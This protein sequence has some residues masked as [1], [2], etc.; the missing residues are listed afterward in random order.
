MRNSLAKFYDGVIFSKIFPT[1]LL[2]WI[3]LRLYLSIF[4]AVF[5]KIYPFT[6]MEKEISTWP[7]IVDVVIWFQRVFFAPWLRWDAVWYLELLTKGYSANNGSTSFHPL[8]ALLSKPL[9]WLGVEPLFSL[10]IT[11][12]LFCLLFFL[13]FYKFSRLDLS[14]E[15]SLT[16][17]M[18]IAFFPISFILFAPYSE[19]VFLFFSTLA[20]YQMRKRYWLLA[21]I[22]MFLASLARQ[23]GVFLAFPMLWY[24][25]EDSG[26]SV[27]E[28]VKGWKGWLAALTAPTGLVIWS[29]YRILY[30]HEGQLNLESWQNFIYSA[31]LSPSAKNILPGQK[32][33]WPWNAFI[34]A[35]SDNHYT[36]EIRN[37]MP[38]TMGIGFVFMFVVAY[39]YLNTAERLYS[40]V[41]ILVSFSMYTGTFNIYAGLP[42][43]LF[44]AV[45]VF[46]GFSNS[47]SKQWQKLLVISLELIF[48]ICMLYLFVAH[49]WIP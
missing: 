37:I 2:I 35:F 25:W 18:L 19:S 4:A 30:L 27:K 33:M 36:L 20:L 14:S 9:Y 47:L 40:L 42:R 16:A 26:K 43:H 41:I 6:S 21:T 10:L 22:S 45:P 48:Q 5:S 24:A 44:L 7:P 31:L 46:I 13:V 17:F 38:I 29:I 1:I 3:T 23:Q 12:S 49:A 15:K 11:S 39:K 32:L 34:T 8:Y 28:L